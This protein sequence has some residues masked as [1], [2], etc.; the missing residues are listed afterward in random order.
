VIGI[1][2]ATLAIYAYDKSAARRGALRV[3]EAVLHVSALFGGAPA[4]LA[5]QRILRHKTAKRGFQI[6]FWVIF[7]FQIVLIVVYAWLWRQK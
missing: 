2:V 1:N 5:A 6:V 4:A 3:P 7:A